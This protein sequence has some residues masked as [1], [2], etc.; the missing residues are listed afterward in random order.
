[1][2]VEWSIASVTVTWNPG[3]AIEGHIRALIRQTRP[4][5]EI[6]VVDNASTDGTGELLKREFPE[7]RV[8]A[9]GRNTGMAGGLCAGLE[10]SCA[11]RHDWIWLFDQDSAPAPTALQELL[12]AL[13]SIPEGGNEI[14]VLAS[15]PVDPDNGTEHI[16]LLWRN[17]LIPVPADCAREPICFADSVIS[18]GSLIR[19]EVVERVGLPR[20]DFFIDFVDH[21]YNLRIRKMG[22]RI[23]VVRA[24]VLYHH[25]GEFHRV[26]RFP[27]A[28]I[29]MRS[30]EPTW[31][32]YFM[33]RNEAFMIW[34]LMGNTRSRAFLLIRFL[35]RAASIVWYDRDKLAKLHLH[36]AGFVDGLAANLSKRTASEVQRRE[37]TKRSL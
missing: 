10:Y 17:R 13:T 15:L 5:D 34:H 28:R 11:K 20:K 21:E 9:E 1:M 18:S 27:L 16:G 22:Y 6:V 36:L 25:L 29:R 30:C 31:R 12:N 32:Y 33:S 14:G 19:R 24:S 3:R 2:K 35:R 37:P 26:R 8:L 7:V 4:L 23:A